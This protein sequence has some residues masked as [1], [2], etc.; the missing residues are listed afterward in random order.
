[1]DGT[2]QVAL[3][4]LDAL[5]S[6]QEMWEELADN[7]ESQLG[8]AEDEDQQIGLMLRLA[9]L[10]ESR[11]ELIESAIEIYRQVL[12]REPANVEAL[13]ALERLGKL[14][15][16]ELSIAEIL[17][18]LYRASGDYVKLIGV[19]E[20]QVRRTDDIARRVDLLHQIATLHEDA[21]DDMNSAIRTRMHGRLRKTQLLS[22]RK[23]AL[24]ASHLRPI[25]LLISP[26]C[27]RALRPTKKTRSS[28]ARSSR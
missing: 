20:V 17:E 19:H 2:S 12:D 21:G 16:F 27:L 28:P 3:T 5:F 26:R 4:A 7:L 10:R 18:P 25:A 23:T 15:E 1:M 6:R 11:M 14:E 24:R 8:L 13:E 9:S 22:L